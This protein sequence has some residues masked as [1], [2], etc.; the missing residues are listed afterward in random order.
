MAGPFLDRDYEL[1]AQL[2]STYGVSPGALAGTDAFKHTSGKAL[3]RAKASA[4]RDGEKSTAS[5][6]VVTQYGGR[7][8][9]TVTI[10]TYMV[11]SGTVAVAPDVDQLLEAHFG[12]KLTP[13]AATTTTSGSTGVTLELTAGGGAASGIVAGMLIAVDQDGAGNY[14]VRRVTALATDTVTVDLAFTTAS[15]ATGRAVQPLTTYK[16]SSAALK[17]VHLWEFLNGDN[18]RHKAAGCTMR[19]LAGDIDFTQQVP[20]GTFK[21]GGEGGAVSAQTSTSR[22]TPTTAGDVLVPTVGT[23]WIGSTKG[24]FIKGGFASD[25]GIELRETESCSLTPTG[26]KRTGR[27]SVTASLSVLL[28]TAAEGY[29]DNASAQTAYSVIVQLGVLAGKRVAWCLPKFIP[30]TQ[31][32]AEAGEVSLDLAGNALATTTDDEIYLGIG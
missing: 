11:P 29:Y 12:T 26:V 30:D 19:T 2:E 6:S 8:K 20:M 28:T 17:T 15:V 5:A 10:E 3:K 32:G 13:T 31:D 23:V 21:F 27:F 22:P 24:C 7:E 1:F 9:S 18:F 4:K 14:E 25:N 16:F